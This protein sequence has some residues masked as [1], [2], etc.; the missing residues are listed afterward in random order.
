[1]RIFIGTEEI[2][3]IIKGL[4]QGFSKLGVPAEIVLGMPHPFKYSNENIGWVARIY[5]KIGAL[6]ARTTRQQLFLKIIS[7]ALHQIWGWLVLVIAL[8]KFDAFIFVFG[9]TITNSQLEL[10]LLKWLGKK[11]IFIYVGSD[12]RPRF[13]DG[14]YFPNSTNNPNYK[15][16]Y[17]LTKK[18]KRKI[19]IQEHYADYIVNSPSTAHY[20]ERPFINWFAMGI[21]K[22]SPSAIVHK[23]T[24]SSFV[25]ILHSPS[26]PTIKGTDIILQTIQTLQSK[27]HPI[28]LIKIEGMSNR[29]VLEELE[30]CDF[31]IDQLYSDTPLAVFATEAACYGKPAIVGGYFSEEIHQYLNQEEIPPSLFV[32]PEA[33][34]AAIEK[35]I[36]DPDFRQALGEKARMFVNS[37]WQPEAVAARYLQLIQGNVPTHWWQD[38]SQI[39]YVYGC[40]MSQTQVIRI[41][42]EMINRFGLESLQIPDKPQMQKAFIELIKK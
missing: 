33:L 21:P 24:T 30:K 34:E 9:K 35:L 37:H 11:I 23:K 38:P 27:G 15:N 6:K 17:L 3:G 16:A 19:N 41:V 31:V 28:K 40:G 36:V 8:I 39:R 4:A 2:G 5:Q 13:I 10:I 14:V 7:I 18:Q 29:V 22:S 42:S 1:M 20:H 26:N 12:T 25:R 32:L